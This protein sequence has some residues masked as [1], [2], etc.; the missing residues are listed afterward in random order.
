M[1]DTISF[2][3]LDGSSKELKA[4]Q[5]SF[6]LKKHGLNESKRPYQGILGLAPHSENVGPLV[7]EEMYK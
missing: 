2:G 6:L 4:D 5:M 1:H 7:V 3:P